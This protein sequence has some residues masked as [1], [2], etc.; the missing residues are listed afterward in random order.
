MSEAAFEPDFYPLYVIKAL[1][2]SYTIQECVSNDRKMSKTYLILFLNSDVDGLLL[3][4]H[5]HQVLRLLGGGG[6]EQHRL[7]LFGQEPHNLL[8]LLFE[9]KRNISLF[10][11]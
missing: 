10:K 3:E 11:I 8:H 7:P 1:N 5:G 2:L 9:T 6:A 4:G